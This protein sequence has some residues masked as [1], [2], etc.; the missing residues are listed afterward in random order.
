MPCQKLGKLVTRSVHSHICAKIPFLQVGS[1][2]SLTGSAQSA[3]LTE[4]TESTGPHGPTRQPHRGGHAAPRR[5]PATER[6][7][8]PKKRRRLAGVGR[9]RA[10]GGLRTCGLDLRVRP[11]AAHTMVTTTGVGDDRSI[12][13]GERRRQRRSGARREKPTGRQTDRGWSRSNRE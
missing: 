3:E 2:V 5:S 10:T 9:S 6:L 8:R 13:G 12:A 7:R 11:G 1:H 4:S